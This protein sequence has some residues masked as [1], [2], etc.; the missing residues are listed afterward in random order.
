MNRKPCK[1]GSNAKDVVLLRV[2]RDQVDILYLP[3]VGI[4]KS[5]GLRD[6]GNCTVLEA[7]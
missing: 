3:T 5:D 7:G 6:E 1:I 2:S 4:D